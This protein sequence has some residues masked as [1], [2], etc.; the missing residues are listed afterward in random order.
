MSV[1]D[2][3]SWIVYKAKAKLYLFTKL[4]VFFFFFN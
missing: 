4:Q 3:D 2:E 1:W